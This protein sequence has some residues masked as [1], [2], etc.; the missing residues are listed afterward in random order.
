MTL[1]NMLYATLYV[2]VHYKYTL[3]ITTANCMMEIHDM[4]AHFIVA[5][6]YSLRQQT[7]LRQPTIHCSN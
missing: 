1:P 4:I 5:T 7:S 3:T 2:Y 6:N